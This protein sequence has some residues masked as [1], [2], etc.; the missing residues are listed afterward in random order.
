LPRKIGNDSVLHSI[1]FCPSFDK[2][3]ER[4][5]MTCKSKRERER[6]RERE[7]NTE[8]ESISE[9]RT[10]LPARLLLSQRPGNLTS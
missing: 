7:R 10:R 8:E 6:E 2:I 5:F 4:T 1:Y 9:S 3:I